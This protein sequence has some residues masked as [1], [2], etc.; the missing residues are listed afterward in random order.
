MKKTNFD[1]SS[2]TGNSKF[3]YPSNTSPISYQ[4]AYKRMKLKNEFYNGQEGNGR[5]N[6]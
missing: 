1:F 4:K 3:P 2:Q 6:G 5:E